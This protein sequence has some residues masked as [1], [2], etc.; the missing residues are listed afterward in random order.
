MV[1]LG[2]PSM[3]KEEIIGIMA[4]LLVEIDVNLVELVYSWLELMSTL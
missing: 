2:L 3:P 4:Y 1:H